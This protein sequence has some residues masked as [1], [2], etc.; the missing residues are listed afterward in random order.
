M[1]E[2]QLRI[3]EGLRDLHLPP[4][5]SAWPPAPGW[6]LVSFLLAGL[7]CYSLW[8][9]LKARQSC[10]PRRNAVSELNT[11]FRQWQGDCDQ[12]RYLQKS[13]FILRQLAITLAGRGGVS[14]LSG[15]QWVHW[16]ERQSEHV[17]S[18]G[19][20]F[21]LAYGAYRKT[22]DVSIEQLHSDYVTWAKQCIVTSACKCADIPQELTDPVHQHKP[23]TSAADDIEQ[24]YA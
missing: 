15:E 7:L 16:L 23:V 21:A 6:W 3:A 1:T 24:P 9:I 5:V 20:K 19:A 11:A 13:H 22:I 10:N 8:R 2:E 14:R 18:E 17:F 4:P 12:Q